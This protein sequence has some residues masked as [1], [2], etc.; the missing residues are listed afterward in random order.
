MYIAGAKIRHCDTRGIWGFALHF[1][2]LMHVAASFLQGVAN[3][4]RPH[5]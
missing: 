2:Q 1:D 3:Q 5:P 4:I